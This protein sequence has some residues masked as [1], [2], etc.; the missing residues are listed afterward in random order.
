MTQAKKKTPESSRVRLHQWML[1]EHA[2][3][4]GNV[5]GGTIMKLVDEAGAIAAMRH[6]QR[7]CVTIAVDSMIFREPVHLGALLVCDA[8][9]TYVGRSSIETSVL[10]HSENPITG[11]LTHTN[12]AH[13]VYIALGDDDRPTAV[14]PLELET[15]ADRLAF[16]Q[17]AL[18]QQERL[19]RKQRE[20]N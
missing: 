20:G 1:P 3:A 18:R 4:L 2:N 17:G 10:V 19:A 6:A 5:H 16:E 9:V 12:S 11:E 8:R 15:D 13:L 14:P 7:R